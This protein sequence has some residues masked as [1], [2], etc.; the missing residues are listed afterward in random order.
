MTSSMKSGNILLITA[1]I[2]SLAIPSC[3]PSGR[4]TVEDTRDFMG[5][6]IQVKVSI[7]V[8]EDDKKAKDAIA[9]AFAEIKRVEDIFSVYNPDSEISAVNRLKAGEEKT[10]SPDAFDLIKRSVEYS[11]VTAGAFDITIKPLV[12]LWRE[13]REN[14]KIPEEAAVKEALL[15]VGYEGIVLDGVKH[16]ISFKK[17]GMVLDFG[18]IA[19]GYAT[20]VAI[21]ALKRN[22]IDS[23]VVRSGGNIYC[24]GKKT[25]EEM[26]KVGIQHPRDKNKLFMDIK[27]KDEAIDTAGDYEKYFILDQKRYSH[28]I[29]PR[30]GYP[31]G[32]DVVSSTVMAPDAVSA[33]A[34]STAFA[35]LGPEKG[36]ACAETIKGIDAILV[37]KRNNDFK[38]VMT[39]G[40]KK[41]HDILEEKI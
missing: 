28:I 34:L 15:R 1:A 19:K 7:D 4:R 33:D 23:A 26:W 14:N 9:E 10:L 21:G 40:I 27:L 3:G 12:D 13:A 36:I 41:R 8:R 11:R 22:G 16:T 30:T 38:V 29:D 6:S 32:D 31:I 2:L 5:T 25:G 17:D 18:A 24:L 20:D 39:E 35:I 37:F